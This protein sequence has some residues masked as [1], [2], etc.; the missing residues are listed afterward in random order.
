MSAETEDLAA[1]EARTQTL[2]ASDTLTAPTRA[3]LQARMKQRFEPTD[4]LLPPQRRTLE[5][6]CLRLIPDPELVRR[7]ALPAAFE[8][9]L[10]QGL[11]RG[12]RYAEAPADV[13]L[14]RAGLNALDAAAADRGATAFPDLGRHQQDALLKAACR[15]EPPM[16]D[17]ALQHW[18][19]EL[20][21]ALTE[22]YYAHP[23]VQVSIGY[24][25]MAD[26]HG[27]R[28]VGLPA[29]AAEAERLGQ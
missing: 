20:L 17:R 26:A 2:L 10:A 3:V 27:Q 22:I 14:L 15:G 7:I 13:L 8:A 16:N 5:A 6:A 28:A 24:D 21:T 1:L 25:G 23:L 9:R 19:E 12:W 11:G 4:L 18:F 29:V